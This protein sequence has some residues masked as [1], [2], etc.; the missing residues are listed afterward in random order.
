MICVIYGTRP[1]FIKMVPLIKEFKKRHIPLKVLSTGQ[2]ESMLNELYEL[3]E[4]F[5]DDDL[6]LWKQSSSLAELNGI[7][8]PSLFNYFNKN[9]IKH[10]FV[11]GD[12]ATTFCSAYAGFLLKSK[13]YH[14]EAGLRTYNKYSPWPEEINRKLVGSIA[15][16]HFCATSLNLN[17]LL[18]EGIDKSKCIEVGN[19]VIDAVQFI[20][21]QG[22]DSKLINKFRRITKKRYIL[23]T[24]HRR[25]NWGDG[26]SQMCDALKLISKRLQDFHIIF[27]CHPNP[28]V[29][30]QI[31]E[32]LENQNNIFLYGPQRYDVFIHLL[33]NASLIISDSGGI[34][35]EI[36]A[37]G[38]RMIITRNTTER[39]E[40]INSGHAILS[41]TE[42]NQIYADAIRLIEEDKMMGDVSP[43]GAGDTAARIV[44]YFESKCS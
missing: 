11:Q 24:G 34:Q 14:L 19:T 26:I 6:A 39:Q 18:K 43:F 5:P 9:K 42:P 15:D 13:I 23:V 10:V 7:L 40:A 4:I 16:V 38:K 1:E 21:N 37:L 44:D 3:F 20:S 41:G 30:E 36:T 35:E 22:I 32:I 12:T 27:C 31:S 28:T 29:R 8:I 17:A 33:K 2:H 25:E